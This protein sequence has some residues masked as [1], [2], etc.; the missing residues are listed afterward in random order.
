ME[1][2]MIGQGKGDL[3]IQVTSWA[4]LI[5]YGFFFPLTESTVR[6][7]QTLQNGAIDS[8]CSF[9]VKDQCT[10]SCNNGYTKNPIVQNIMCMDSGDWNFK[11]DKLCSLGKINTTL[12]LFFLLLISLPRLLQDVFVYMSNTVGVL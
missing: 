9:R 10:Y 2:L 7:K 5:V 1:F 8:Q 12:F 11:V 6:C 4:G 3:L